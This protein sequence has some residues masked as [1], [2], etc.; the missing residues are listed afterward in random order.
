MKKIIGFLFGLVIL[1]AC[2]SD[3]QKTVTPTTNKVAQEETIAV[4]PNK[5]L[6][7]QVGGMSCEMGCGA[8]IRKE[9]Y[10][11]G[12]VKE[13][14]YDF[15]MGREFNK[16]TISFDANKINQE[17]LESIISNINNNQFTLKDGELHDLE[18]TEQQDSAAENSN[19][20]TTQKTSSNIRSS[21]SITSLAWISMI[22]S[23]LLK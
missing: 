8:A 12:A 9:L 11:T 19:F 23:N 18:A 14:K 3:Q 22:V 16:A 6:E 17:K 2:N 5:L 20:G 7:I 15:M 13:V 21:N 10:A 1:S 4:T